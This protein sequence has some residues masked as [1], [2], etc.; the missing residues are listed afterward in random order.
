MEV[1]ADGHELEFLHRLLKKHDTESRIPLYPSDHSV[2]VNRG[3]TSAV[4][5]WKGFDAFLVYCVI[6][7]QFE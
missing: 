3:I 5:L 1:Q 4:Q 7:S 2:N 6:L